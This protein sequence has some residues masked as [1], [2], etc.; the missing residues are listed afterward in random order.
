[1]EQYDASTQAAESCLHVLYVCCVAK[2]CSK[3]L[4]QELARFHL[5]HAGAAQL[6]SK[7]LHTAKPPKNDLAHGFI[8]ATPTNGD[9][10]HGDCRAQ[11]IPL[12]ISKLNI[13]CSRPYVLT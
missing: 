5:D 3:D 1:M 11:I 9:C 10:R 2:R 13:L 6:K 7:I 4:F 8:F 12:W